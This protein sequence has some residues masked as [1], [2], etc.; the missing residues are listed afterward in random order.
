MRRVDCRAATSDLIK[1]AAGSVRQWLA[2]CCIE[3]SLGRKRLWLS[4]LISTKP[5]ITTLEECLRA[6]AAIPDCFPTQLHSAVIVI[7][8]TCTSG[9][10]CTELVSKKVVCW[11]LTDVLRRHMMQS[12]N[13]PDWG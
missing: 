1:P 9:L 3:Q 8:E 10:G 12:V 7:V 5:H 13:D 2:K 6:A 4:W 11:L